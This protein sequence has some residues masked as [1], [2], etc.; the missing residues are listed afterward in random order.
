L[1]IFDNHG[2]AVVPLATGHVWLLL[3]LKASAAAMRASFT[4]PIAWEK[5]SATEH[6]G[7]DVPRLDT[8]VFAGEKPSV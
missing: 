4:S 8:G 2:G 6:P 5:S 3:A 1:D 7:T